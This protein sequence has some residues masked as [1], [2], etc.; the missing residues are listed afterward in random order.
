MEL[1][2]Y[3]PSDAVELVAMWRA[4]FEHGM[5][6]R[7]PNP[8]EGQLAFFLT[9]VV[10]QNRVRVVKHGGRVVAFSASTPESVTQL[11]VQVQHIGQGI[12]S[13][14]IGLAKSDS[15]GSL[16]LYTF[17]QNHNAR[18]FYG[19]HGFEE[20]ERESE[21]MYK[22]EAIKYVWARERAATPES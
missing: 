11:F 3:D 12:G 21:N 7:D 4:S 2:A 14:L 22:L 20:V 5:G 10:P 18:R 16:W 9:E 15:S 19:H 13:W 1:V 8:I 6:I 17:T